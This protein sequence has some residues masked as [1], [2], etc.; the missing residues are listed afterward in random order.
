MFTDIVGYSAL[1]Q[2]DEALSLEM[3][4]EHRELL[5]PIFTRFGGKEIETIGDAFFI[6][7]ASALEAVK[8]AFEIQFS[9]FGRNSLETGERKIILRIGI[10]LGDVMQMV[11]FPRVE[12]PMSLPPVRL[13][14]REP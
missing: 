12:K 13:E 9:L 14:L 2:K 11:G 6:E 10:H 5:R 8:C 4:E 7:F 3:L 1:A